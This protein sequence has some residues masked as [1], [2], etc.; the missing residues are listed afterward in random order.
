MKTEEVRR[1]SRSMIIKLGIIPVK[2]FISLICCRSISCEVT[3]LAAIGL[4]SL[5]FSCLNV[6]TTNVSKL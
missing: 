4:M 2:P 5:L 6:E 3:T 1:V